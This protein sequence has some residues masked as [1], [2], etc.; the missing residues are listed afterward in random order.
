MEAPSG[1]GSVSIPLSSLRGVR[2]EG[3]Q[4]LDRDLETL[5]RYLEETQAGTQKEDPALTRLIQKIFSAM[6]LKEPES[7]AAE[8]NARNSSRLDELLGALRIQLQ[9][10]EALFLNANV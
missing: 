2:D 4:S 10:S 8:E 3:A 6:G 1:N 5:R 9:R 7:S